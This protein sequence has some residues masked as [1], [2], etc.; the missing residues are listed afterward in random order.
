MLVAHSRSQVRF[1]LGSMSSLAHA[2]VQT[3][4]WFA[5]WFMLPLW[6]ILPLATIRAQSNPLT[7]YA[8]P[9]ANAIIF[10]NVN[11]VMN[12]PLATSQN[13]K[14]DFDKAYASGLVAVPPATGQ[15]MI[16]S[17]LD[18]STWKPNLTTAVFELN[19][20]FGLN[21][22]GR[23]YAGVPDTIGNQA[24]LLLSQGV[25]VIQAGER[26]AAVISSGNRQVVSRW[27]Q[28]AAK[29]SADAL[30]DY[31]QAAAARVKISDIVLAI[32]LQNA[33]PLAVIE[34][35]LKS[36]PLFAKQTDEERSAT[37]RLLH[38]LKG[39]TLEV[40][41]KQVADSRLVVDFGNDISGSAIAQ[42]GKEILIE[43]L[44]DV[45]LMMDDLQ[46]WNGRAEG[47]RY[48]LQGKLS[49]D[50]IRSVMRLIELPIGN[51][52]TD[53]KRLPSGNNESQIAY[54]TQQY[55]RS[56]QKVMAQ[57]DEITKRD[58]VAISRYAKWFSN[59]ADE[60]DALPI[61]NV[62]PSLIEFSQKLSQSFRQCS[63]AIAGIR[64]QAGARGAQVWNGVGEYYIWTNE[65]STARN[66]LR[67]EEQARGITSA[68][69][70]YREVQNGLQE[71]RRTMVDKYKLDF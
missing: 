46:S 21:V 10:F 32:D 25:Y 55:F 27:L 15:L 7:S 31:L 56:I 71:V 70:I 67:K 68:R 20:A 12:S 16:S 40:I 18:I 58:D 29:P 69:G 62:D 41:V 22:V 9:N 1:A 45:G 14:E 57:I 8:A 37:A 50:G 48:I 23:Q 63:D 35:K 33:F 42:H 65:Q 38:S 44:S 36:S 11:Q 2:M 28:N 6:M 54:T 59:W 17:E 26:R 49:G 53:E 47:N 24:S 19:E 66:A 64:I 61:L 34:S 52:V 51:F 3:N 4:R 30:T 60:I 13:W 43:A 39:L 5:F